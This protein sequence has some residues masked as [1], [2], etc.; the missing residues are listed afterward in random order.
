MLEFLN[1]RLWLQWL[2][3]LDRGFL[4]LLLLPLVVAAV[5]L[6][7]HFFGDDRER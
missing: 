6:W 5:G 2:S 7:A 1:P 3:E 4:F